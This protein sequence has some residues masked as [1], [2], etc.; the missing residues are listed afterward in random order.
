MT[1]DV[2]VVV[3]VDAATKIYFYFNIL[4]DTLSH[5]CVVKVHSYCFAALKMSRS[6]L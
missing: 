1:V 3:L 2:D 4:I 6:H 5:L